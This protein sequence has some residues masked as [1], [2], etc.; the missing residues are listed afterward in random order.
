MGV[1]KRAAR[2]L[3][4]LQRDP[5]WKVDEIVEAGD[6]VPDEIPRHT[7]VLVGGDGRYQWL[8]FDC[9]CAKG[10]RIMLNL[11][12]ARK[13]SWRLI[14]QKSL[15]VYPSVDYRGPDRRCHY[16]IVDGRIRWVHS[17]EGDT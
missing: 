16:L 7:A 5:K 14:T 2:W 13:P 17:R 9:A 6:L 4:G 11:Q 1:L 15:T 8:A 12:E 3:R 10:H